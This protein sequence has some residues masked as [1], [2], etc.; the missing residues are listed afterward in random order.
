MVDG[1][2]VCVCVVL[3]AVIVEAVVAAQSGQSSKSN[4]IGE[5]DLSASVDPHLKNG[6]KSGE[7]DVFIP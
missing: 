3:V 5:E 2:C 6:Q 1:V 7:S 4:G